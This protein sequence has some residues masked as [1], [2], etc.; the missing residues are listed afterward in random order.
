MAALVVIGVVAAWLFAAAVLVQ[1]E[2]YDGLSAICNARYFLGL[3]TFYFF[4]RGPLMAWVQMPAEALK[5]W[6]S[7]HPLDV[8]AHHAAMALVHLAYV[9]VVFR[10]LTGQFGHSWSTL[11]AFLTGITSYVFFSYAPFLSHD[12]APGAL[13]IWMLIWSEVFS[14]QP[15]RETWV[16]LVVLGT[17]GPLVKQT[18]GVFWIAVL[19]AHVLP[20]VL[21]MPPQHRTSTRALMWLAIGAATSALLTWIVYGIVLSN[22][23]PAMNL[24]LRPY[25]NLQYLGHIYDGTD[26]RFPL[27]IYLKNFW[28][29]GRLTTLLLIPG[30]VY[31]LRGSRLQRR[32][33][34]AWI[35]SIILMH[36]LPLRE[37]RYIAFLAPLSTFIIVPAVRVLGRAR[38][39]ALGHG[40]RVAVRSRRCGSRGIENR[41]RP[42][43]ATASSGRL[44]EPLEDQGRLRA[45]LF[46][47]VSMLSF[48]APD[49]SPLAADRYHRIFHAGVRQIGVLYGYPGRRCEN[50][51]G[52]HCHRHRDRSGG[53]RVAV[54]QW[55][56]RVRSRLDARSSTWEASRSLRDSRRWQPCPFA[57]G[58]MAIWRRLTA[59][60]SMSKRSRRAEQPCLSLMEQ[61]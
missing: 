55:H 45:P 20:T 57:G 7:L 4:D 47:N 40:R 22:W 12:L 24:W 14:R 18:Y 42:F 28:A 61:R 41:A 30:F 8:R 11:I 2:Y 9:V 46:H 54:Q 48:P 51:A 15:R 19:A 23:A 38:D 6:L 25:V 60:L 50:A 58:Q 5:S 56:S 34:L 31:S 10:A 16:L 27:W 13:L 1:I 35:A 33:A 3:S 52:A 39:R 29:Y 26:V 53:K 49:Q 17:L 43:I 44:L 59:Q 21:R 32:V 37:V 36:V